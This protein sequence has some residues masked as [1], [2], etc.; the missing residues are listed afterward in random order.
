M[1]RAGMAPGAR[2]APFAPPAHAVQGVAFP[3][4]PPGGIIGGITAVFLSGDRG[5]ARHFRMPSTS[6]K[7]VLFLCTGNYY[8]SRFS[9]YLF[10]ALALKRKL[11]WQATSRG[12]QTWMADGLGPVSE[13]TVEALSELGIPLESKPRFPM[14]LVRRDLESADL[15]VAVKEAEHRAMMEAQFPD[16]ADRIQY[17]AIDDL[18]CAGP[19]EAL[20]LCRV[21]VERLIDRLV[22]SHASEAA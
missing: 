6:C 13:F 16:W 1:L 17:W 5:L 12:L 10:N 3:G 20:P 11:P 4:S 7:T 14:P 15:V 9:E 22:Q 21:E 8:R 19:E 18:D 2:N